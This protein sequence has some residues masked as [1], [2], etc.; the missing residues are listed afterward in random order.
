MT[1]VC[2]RYENASF[3]NFTGNDELKNILSNVMELKNN[4]VIWGDVG[5][6]KTHLAYAI[7]NKWCDK[8]NING[9]Y[10]YRSNQIVYT[11][12]KDIIDDIRAMWKSGDY[13]YSIVYYCKKA[14]VLIIDEVGVQYGS[15]SER[16]ELFDIFNDRYNNC[17]PT[18]AMSNYSPEKIKPVLGLR[19]YDRLF[20]GAKVFELK[21]KSHRQ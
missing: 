19:I 13:S 5:T 9:Y 15:D 21:G 11:S 12:V 6:G 14:K 16:I 4:V 3:E 18:I 8:I 2:K 10:M 1:K 17:L 20:G 7:L